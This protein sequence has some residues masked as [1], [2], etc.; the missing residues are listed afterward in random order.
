MVRTHILEGTYPP[1]FL[2]KATDQLTVADLQMALLKRVKIANYSVDL[3][4]LRLLE[5]LEVGLRDL[6]LRTQRIGQ[7]KRVLTL[8]LVFTLHRSVQGGILK[9]CVRIDAQIVL[10]VDSWE[11]F[12]ID[13]LRWDRIFIE[14]RD[15]VLHA[16]FSNATLC[17]L[18]FGLLFRLL[19]L[20]VLFD[21]EIEE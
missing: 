3:E 14:V 10:T 5:L 8:S 20:V 16:V 18:L 7:R 9:D 19:G 21:F 17:L 13:H 15:H 11:S 6:G 4:I 2:R 12:S 1:V